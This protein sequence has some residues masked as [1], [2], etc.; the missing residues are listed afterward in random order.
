MFNL[1]HKEEE[2]GRI[3]NV[4]KSLSYDPLGSV[5]ISPSDILIKTI[6]SRP[7][8]TPRCNKAYRTPKGS[9]PESWTPDL[10]TV[11]GTMA[12]PG[13]AWF[14]VREFGPT[15][16]TLTDGQWLN[17]RPVLVKHGSGF[18]EP[19]LQARPTSPSCTIVD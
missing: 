1:K 5:F 9:M 18:R 3:T 7:R 8:D 6:L 2:E 16:E 15:H 19:H 11:Y 4:I 17:T 10:R 12:R 13:W 14:M